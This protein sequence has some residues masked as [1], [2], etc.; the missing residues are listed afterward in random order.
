MSRRQGASIERDLLC[1]VFKVPK[2]GRDVFV[3]ASNPLQKRDTQLFSHSAWLFSRGQ[4][5]QRNLAS[6]IAF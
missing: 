6:P 2:D 4:A 3:S 1:A 5:F